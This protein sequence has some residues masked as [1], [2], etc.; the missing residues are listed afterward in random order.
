LDVWQLTEKK[1]EKLFKDLNILKNI[2]VKQLK[3]LEQEEVDEK[4]VKK[5]FE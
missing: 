2:E 5:D 4:L 3:P 1:H